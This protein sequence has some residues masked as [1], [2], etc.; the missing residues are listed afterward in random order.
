MT[1]GVSDLSSCTRNHGESSSLCCLLLGPCSPMESKWDMV[2]SPDRQE[3]E[4]VLLL[5]QEAVAVKIW[6]IGAR[7]DSLDILSHGMVF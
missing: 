2:D 6:R 4:M 1:H 7:I 3:A 5:S